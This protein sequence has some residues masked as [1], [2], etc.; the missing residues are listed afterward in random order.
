MIEWIVIPFLIF[1]A[2]IL[3]V[4]I[5]T[6]RVIF[7]AKGMKYLAP[8]LGFVEVLIWLLAI[9]QI[10]Q[11]LTHWINYIAYAAGFG[12]GNYVGMLIEQ[13]LALGTVIVRIITQTDATLLVMRLRGENYG[14]TSID[15]VGRDGPVKLLFMVVKRQELQQ[16]VDL[17]HQ[18]NPRAFYS[19]E[20]VRSVKEG[21][22][23]IRRR[24]L[25]M[26]DLS[27]SKMLRK[28]K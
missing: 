17:V 27:L 13:R 19:V 16:V 1:L 3:D 23:P 21:I 15:A 9:G 12:M 5:G 26:R 6:L 18:H 22:F 14:V 28:A 10:L 20:D 24:N 8:A 4:S 11:N 7:V 2:R 25:S